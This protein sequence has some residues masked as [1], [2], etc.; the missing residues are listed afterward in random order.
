M[1]KH[2]HA[3]DTHFRLFGHLYALVVLLQ[4][5]LQSKYVNRATVIDRLIKFQQ[6]INE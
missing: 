6:N 5:H 2:T 1:D 3:L 4:G